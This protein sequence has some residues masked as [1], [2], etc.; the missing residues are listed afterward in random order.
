M[1]LCSIVLWII[2]FLW[3]D[4]L[5]VDARLQTKCLVMKIELGTMFNR[6]ECN[7]EIRIGSTCMLDDKSWPR[8]SAQNLA[9]ILAFEND[10]LLKNVMTLHLDGKCVNSN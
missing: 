5:L 9:I 4:K 3:M 8:A 6:K 1:L 10:G 7:K 2:C